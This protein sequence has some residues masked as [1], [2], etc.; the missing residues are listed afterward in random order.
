MLQQSYC[1]YNRIKDRDKA[2]E[3][4]EA[5]E[6]LTNSLSRKQQKKLKTKLW[7][8]HEYLMPSNI[9][10]LKAKLKGFDL[11]GDS[12]VAKGRAR[13]E[14][15]RQTCDTVK[16][17]PTLFRPDRALKERGP[18][19]E[20]KLQSNEIDVVGNKQ[21]MS[22]KAK[23]KTPDRVRVDFKRA[24]LTPKS[25]EAVQTEMYSLPRSV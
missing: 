12:L 16:T 2:E 19:Q 14:Q 18:V 5:M 4:R 11:K 7:D 10:S 22:V 3:L 1:A 20:I 13:N 8:I 9:L 6:H 23:R 21:R 24:S 15:R 25:S 17:V